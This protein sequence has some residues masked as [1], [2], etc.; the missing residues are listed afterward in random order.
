MVL[1]DYIRPLWYDD[2]WD[3]PTD[4]LRLGKTLT[5]VTELEDTVL[6]RSYKL[7]GF[8]LWEKYEKVLDLMEQWAN[9]DDKDIVCRE[10]VS[11]KFIY[12]KLVYIK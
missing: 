7:I 2:H 8:A 11:N 9:S 5:M 6:N 10:A 3:I 1:V 12:I 4:C